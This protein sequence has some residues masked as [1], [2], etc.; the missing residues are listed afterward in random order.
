MNCAFDWYLLKDRK[1]GAKDSI[2]V[3]LQFYR[4]KAKVAFVW[5]GKGEM[6]QFLG[7]PH[8][9]LLRASI[10]ISFYYMCVLLPPQWTHSPIHD[11]HKHNDIVFV[12][13]D[14][15]DICIHLSF[16]LASLL[17]ETPWCKGVKSH[18]NNKLYMN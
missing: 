3:F 13:R 5:K 11:N 15:C 16:S 9:A 1:W 10:S 4:A 2:H 12:L 14:Y 17:G 6:C 7:K 8:E 18:Y